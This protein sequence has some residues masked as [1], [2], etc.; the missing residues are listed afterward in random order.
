MVNG[1]TKLQTRLQRILRI[2]RILQDGPA[3][4]ETLARRF[5]VNVRSIERDIAEL[6][7]AGCGL[8]A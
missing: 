5:D 6:R 4:V 8:R 7:A 2:A 3:H 1:I